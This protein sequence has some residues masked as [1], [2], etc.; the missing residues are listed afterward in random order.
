MGFV[1]VVHETGER[2]LD[3]V[4]TTMPLPFDDQ[5]RTKRL[6]AAWMFSAGG[7]GGAVT[8]TETGAESVVAPLLSAAMAVRTYEPERALLQTALHGFVETSAI[9][10]VPA[11]N[12]TLV[13]LP[14]RS[15]ASA[16]REWIEPEA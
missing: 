8:L 12:W 10:F 6:L 5:D 1:S 11:K 2:R 3:V 7:C 9:L 14:S 13:T 15:V 16:A 4:C